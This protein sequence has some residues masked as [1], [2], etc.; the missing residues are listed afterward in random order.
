MNKIVIT[1]IALCSLQGYATT[2]GDSA[3]L[4]LNHPAISPDGKTVA[5]SYKGDIYTVPATGGE[6]RAV[7]SN[8]AYDS[9]PVWSPDSKTIA[10]ASDRDGTGMDVYAISSQ[11]GRAVRLT[12][13]GGSETPKGFLNDSTVLFSAGIMPST[14][15]RS[16]T[17][18]QLYSVPLRAG[19]RPHM[20]LPFPIGAVDVD[21]SG[22]MLY[23]DKK[24]YEDVL[25]KHERSSGTADIW[26]DDHGRYTRLTTFNE[27]GRASC[28][29]RV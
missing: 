24:S 20:V 19:A 6:A 5:F 16:Y 2:G 21:A 7:T 9:Y 4:W 26:L 3:P 1:A 17:G 18:A 22:R 8:P 13:A 14:T 11:G 23:Q 29:E 10:F 27:I 15:I 25:R 28:R 12:T